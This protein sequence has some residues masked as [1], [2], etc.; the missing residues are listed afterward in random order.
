MSMVNL[1][2][3]LRGGVVQIL[4]PRTYPLLVAELNKI[5]TPVKLTAIQMQL[6]HYRVQGAKESVDEF[7]G[8]EGRC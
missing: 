7:A 2:A 3:R 5:F 4:Y 1:T 8:Q 6:F